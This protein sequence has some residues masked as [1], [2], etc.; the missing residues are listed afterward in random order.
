M[1]LPNKL[2]ILR[3]LMIP[4][5][6]LFILPINLMGFEPDTWNSFVMGFGRSL[7][8]VLFIIASLTD[9]VDGKIA[10]K[11]NL[12]TS[13]GKF[14]DSLA[15]KMLVISILVALVNVGRLS[16]ILVIMIILRE[17]MVTGIRMLASEK[18]VVMAAAMIGK[19][20]TTIQMVA[21]I[22]ILFESVLIWLAELVFSNASA[23]TISTSVVFVGNTLFVA[24]VIMTIIS[25]LDYMFKNRSY[26]TEK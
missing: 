7:A 18:G 13:L 9:L 21:I 17:F 14:L 10:R 3:I 4:V 11:H 25:G 6:L 22:Y 12:I 1:N 2:S 23:V 20:K 16:S 15:D 5:I 19:I 26:L 24:S 8:G